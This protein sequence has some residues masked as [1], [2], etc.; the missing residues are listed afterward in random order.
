MRQLSSA[1][2]TMVSLD[3]ST[4]HNTIGIVGIYDPSTRGAASGPVTDE[5]VLEYIDAR[6]HVAESFR[7]RLVHVPF[8]LDRPW[9]IRDGDFDLEY[10]VRHIALP[11]PGN[12]RQLCTQ[13]ARIHARPLD[14]SKP[15]W[16]LYLIDG[17]DAV[18]HLPP[19]AFA[20]FL[21]IHHAAID[22]VAGAEILTAIHSREPD[23]GPPPVPDDYQWEPDAVPSD[24]DLLA[25]AAL[26]GAARPVDVLRQAGKVAPQL[27]ALVFDARNPDVTSPASLPKATRFNQVVSPHRVFG[28]AYTTLEVLKEIRAAL[29]EATINDVGVAVV[30]GAI[31]RYLLDKDELPEE[32]MVAMMPISIRPTATRA[33]GTAGSETSTG[34]SGN[35]YSIA[36]ITMATDEADPLERLA[37]IVTSTAHVKDSGAHP[38]RSLMAMSEEAFGGLMGTVQRAAVRA[39][40]RRGLTF[41]AHT[42]VSNVPGPQN[43][44]YFCGA[45]MV[46]TTGLGP[47]LDGMGLNNGIGSY[48]NRVTFCFTADRKAVPDPEV[49]EQCLTGAVEELLEAARARHG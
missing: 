31:R 32:A 38:V 44:M 17:L 7:E 1:D 19:G 2:W 46:D 27:P 30:G 13:I 26:H 18:D 20:V 9:W 41:A 29:P 43:P 4:A 21:R 25:R 33:S 10:H 40:S 36:P 28:T 48:G 3:T 37:R 24:L 49:Y 34:T 23:D 16:E 11:G 12:W 6:L 47:V 39:L 14:L 15:P 42:L 45:R 5:E 35:E 22:G 8:G